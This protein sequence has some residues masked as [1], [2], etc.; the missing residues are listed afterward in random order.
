MIKVGVIGVGYL[1]K[2]HARI[3]SQLSLV[4]GGVQLVGVAD[5]DLER[6]AEIG[7]E[8]GCDSF[9]DYRDLLD[10]ADAVSI[11]TPTTFH[12]DIA[13]ACLKEG[14]DLLI[15][16]PVTVT[17][18]EA[19]ELVEV[20][21]R[22][23]RIIQV[24]HIERF[25]PAFAATAGMVKAPLFI[26]TE[27]VSPYQGRGIDVDITLDLMI[28]DIDLVCSLIGSSPTEIK[29]AGS[30]MITGTIDMA[31]AWLEFESGAQAL[32]RASRISSHKSR[33]LTIHER[34]SQISVDF[35]NMQLHLIRPEGEIMVSHEIPVERKEPL[36]EELKAF[37]DCVRTRN[38]PLVS[39]QAGR[40]ALMVASKIGER[41][42]REI[43]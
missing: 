17:V 4:E 6:A 18:E 5:P 34:D 42:R 37:I 14:K 8:Y 7:R 26:E 11:V 32:L 12:H 39:A 2:H 9:G 25:N 35:Q 22:A 36:K 28:H 23:G 33:R 29:A 43:Q 31:I 3:Y 10:R 19:D 40:E 21:E 30:R 24:G 41:I 38:R 16:K 15:E 20:S 13:M 27:R 1:G